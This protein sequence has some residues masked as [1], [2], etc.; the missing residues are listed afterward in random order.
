L[1]IADFHS[2]PN[3]QDKGALRTAV[4]ATHLVRDCGAMLDG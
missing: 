4:A 3:A 2:K 1:N